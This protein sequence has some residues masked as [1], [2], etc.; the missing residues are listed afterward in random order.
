MGRF[1]VSIDGTYLTQYEYQRER[2]GAFIDAVGRY[3]DNAPVF[4]WQHVLSLNLE[5]RAT[6]AR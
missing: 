3:S 1:A 2:G 4:R 6:G 5:R